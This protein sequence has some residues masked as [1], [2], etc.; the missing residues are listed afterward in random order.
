VQRVLT[1]ELL[2]LDGHT[3]A[4]VLDDLRQIR[5]VNR[6]LGGARLVRNRLA[7]LL[8]NDGPASP[9]RL[10]DVATGSADL[11]LSV[12]QWSRRRGL[13]VEIAALDR[14]PQ[15]TRF[16][17]SELRGISQIHLV[18]GDALDLP[19]L[20]A[21]FHYA[22]CSLFLHQLDETQAVRFLRDLL[23]RVTR[24]VLVNELR[25][26]RLHYVTAWLLARMMTRNPITRHDA[27][28]SVRNAYTPAE[29]RDLADRAGASRVEIF[30]HWPFRVCMVMRP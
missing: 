29:L 27:P 26:E 12:V 10:L 25:R 14:H 24:A 8:K 23:E 18:R 7:L 16:A 22:L 4:E 5:R 19:V 28:A 13:E 1:K 6:Y 30:R 9:L 3:D 15:V 11:P 2:D 21:P 17:A 20:G